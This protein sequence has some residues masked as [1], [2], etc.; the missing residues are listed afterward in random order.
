MFEKQIEDIWKVHD[1]KKRGF[2]TRKATMTLVQKLMIDKGLGEFY[3]PQMTVAF[4]NKVD[5]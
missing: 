2:L 4:I 3:D 1:T 5:K